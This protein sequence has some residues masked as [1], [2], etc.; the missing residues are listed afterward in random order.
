MQAGENMVKAALDTYGRLDILVNNAGI[1]RDRMVFNM[2]EEEWDIV[3]AVHLKGHF[4]TIKAAGLVFRQ[5]RSGRIVNT[6]SSSGLG[7]M[8]QANYAAA[9]EGIVGLTRTV[10]RD[11]GRY[12]ATCNAIRPGAATRLTISPEMEEA[13]RKAE[14]AGIQR[15][16]GGLGSMPPEAIAPLVVYLCTDKAQNINGRDFMVAGNRIGL[17]TIPTV[18]RTIYAPGP[19]WTLDQLDEVFPQ[20]I[21]AGLVNEF[22]PKAAPA[23]A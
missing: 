23:T 9:K 16:G 17:Y 5:Q 6:G 7:N 19:I 22:A 14:A 8:G 1:L 20:T 13:R 18:E 3:I 2:S 12:G 15:G 11:L 10:A 4:S 21:G